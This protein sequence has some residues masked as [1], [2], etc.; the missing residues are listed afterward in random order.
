MSEITTN[1]TALEDYIFVKEQKRTRTVG[2][3]EIPDGI[4]MDY[5][6]GTV[7]SVGPGT[8]EN[9]VFRAPSVIVGDEVVFPRTVGAKINFVN[10][11]ELITVRS[12]DLLEKKVID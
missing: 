7:V 2:L 1:Y 8:Y 11:E 3:M 4:D 10:N 12:C 9:G 5:T 6:F